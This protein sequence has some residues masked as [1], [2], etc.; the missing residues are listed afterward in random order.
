MGLGVQQYINEGLMAVH[1]DSRKHRCLSRTIHL[2]VPPQDDSSFE[3]RDG[4]DLLTVQ[5][6][7][8]QS[9]HT[10]W[11]FHFSHWLKRTRKPNT[12]HETTKQQRDQRM[13]R[14]SPSA[15]PRGEMGPSLP[16]I[17]PES[18][19]CI[20]T[21]VRRTLLAD[22]CQRRIQRLQL[23]ELASWLWELWHG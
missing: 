2:C 12:K 4:V 22:S 16:S 18:P 10:L 9:F 21:H 19:N 6:S 20:V 23:W 15:T 5:T 1:E 7:I 8:A 13:E 17:P 11:F 3:A 14:N